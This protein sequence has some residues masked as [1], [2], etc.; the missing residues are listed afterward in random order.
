[1]WDPEQC[2]FLKM[3]KFIKTT[4]QGHSL[5]LQLSLNNFNGFTNNRIT[6]TDIEFINK[7]FA[8]SD[9][10]HERFNFKEQ[11]ISDIYSPIIIA[12]SN[13]G[14]FDSLRQSLT[15]SVNDIPKDSSMVLILEPVLMSND[16][17]ISIKWGIR[18]IMLTNGVR[19]DFEN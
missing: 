9:Y 12:M 14:I 18:Q 10:L 4:Y 5:Y 7:T 2:E 16:Q 3:H 15:M 1:M 6:Y 11:E 19:E 13:I 8:F 17:C